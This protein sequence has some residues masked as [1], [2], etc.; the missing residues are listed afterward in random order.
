MRRIC[1]LCLQERHYAKVKKYPHKLQLC[2]KCQDVIADLSLT[3]VRPI[4][5]F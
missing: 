2:T 5:P 4:G 3:V 1:S